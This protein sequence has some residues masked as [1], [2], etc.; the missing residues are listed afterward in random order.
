MFNKFVFT[1]PFAQKRHIALPSDCERHNINGRTDGFLQ[2]YGDR[3][4]DISEIPVILYFHGTSC[5]AEDKIKT[6]DRIIRD[7]GL[8]NSNFAIMAVEYSFYLENAKHIGGERALERDAEHAYNYVTKSLGIPE[9]NLKIYGESLGS[10]PALHLA[11]QGKKASE[12]IL[13]CPFSSSYNKI[14]NS[15]LANNEVKN[16]FLQTLFHLI[17]FLFY[18]FID[19]LNNQENIR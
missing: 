8:E 6:H 9:K 1:K 12:F 11:K 2:Q 17:F 5:L 14:A 19:K 15:K 3:S 4:K 10:Y 16:F 18:P 7:L 13:N